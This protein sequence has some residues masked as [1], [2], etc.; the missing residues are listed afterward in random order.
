MLRQIISHLQRYC[1]I[2]LAQSGIFL[3]SMDECLK[4]SLQRN[5]RSLTRGRI[6]LSHIGE[7]I[8]RLRKEKGLRQADLS[9]MLG[10][11]QATLSGYERGHRDVSAEWLSRMAEF[12]DVSVDYLIGLTEVKKGARF[13]DG[14]FLEGVKYRNFYDRVEKLTPEGKSIINNMVEILLK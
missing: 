10:V 12:F 6:S 5:Y 11:P 7:R 8:V 4:K 2:K 3:L 13:L 14:T 1:H 9:R